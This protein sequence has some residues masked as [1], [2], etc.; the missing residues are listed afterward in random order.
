M[1]FQRLVHR[2]AVTAFGHFIVQAGQHIAFFHNLAFAH[3][4][5]AQN[6]AF[7]VLDNLGALRGHH[8]AFGVGYLIQRGEGRP[9]QKYDEE[10]AHGEGQQARSEARPPR[11]GCLHLVGVGQVLGQQAPAGRFGGLEQTA[12]RTRRPLLPGG[13]TVWSGRD[14]ER[15]SVRL[16]GRI[17]QSVP[18]GLNRRG[19]VRRNFFKHGPIPADGVPRPL[20]IYFFLRSGTKT[21]TRGSLGP[22][23]G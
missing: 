21:Q 18:V 20:S 14:S 1:V 2:V 17:G 11:Q 7:Q 5:G 13:L 8:L 9:G 22:G 12:G 15:V 16:R 10:Q 19:R 4:D 6:S 3:L 23:A